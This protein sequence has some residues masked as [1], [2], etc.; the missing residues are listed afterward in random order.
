MYVAGAALKNTLITRLINRHFG[1]FS[2]FKLFFSA[3][4]DIDMRKLEQDNGLIKRLKSVQ[5]A[6]GYLETNPKHP[7]LRIHK[8]QSLSGFKGEEVFEAYAEN[9]IPAAYMIFWHYGPCKGNITII[10]ITKH[11]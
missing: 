10:A 1:A 5:R 3:Q 8:Y 9:K 4:A 6:F 11:P 7:N 2:V